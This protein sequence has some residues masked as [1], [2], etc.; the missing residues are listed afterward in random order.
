MIISIYIILNTI[1]LLL[2]YNKFGRIINITSLFTTL[3][4]FSGALSCLG[5]FGLRIPSF[6]VHMYAWMFVLIVDAIFLSFA[7]NRNRSKEYVDNGS[8]RNREEHLRIIRYHS[9]AK[10]IQVIALVLIMP[11]LIKTIPM[12]MESGGLVAVRIRYFSGTNF[13]SVFQDLFF[14]L[15]AIS[16]A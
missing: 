8:D 15:I 7:T 10:Y 13:D 3:W 1:V 6:T 2:S 11:L 4:M 12:Y 9:R 16:N 5:L 14:R